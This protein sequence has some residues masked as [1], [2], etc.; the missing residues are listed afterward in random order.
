MYNTK[1]II[2]NSFIQSLTLYIYGTVT[3]R[4]VLFTN[5]NFIK[6]NC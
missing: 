2:T 3:M 4:Q 5:L 1:S 6:L